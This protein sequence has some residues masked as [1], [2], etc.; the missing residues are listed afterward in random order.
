ML[1]L[2]AGLVAG[3]VGTS[4]TAPV[5][6]MERN[7]SNNLHFRSFKRLWMVLGCWLACFFDFFEL[8]TSEP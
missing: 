6:G 3:I 8:W 7:R 4:V 2:G 1:H 5:A